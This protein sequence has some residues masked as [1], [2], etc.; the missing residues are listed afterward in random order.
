MS[1]KTAPAPYGGADR[2]ANRKGKTY[3]LLA[4]LGAEN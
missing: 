2:S 3:T 4:L 1:R